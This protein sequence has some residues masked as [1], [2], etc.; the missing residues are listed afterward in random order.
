MTVA[1]RIMPRVL[2]ELEVYEVGLWGTDPKGK[3]WL[4]VPT[5]ALTGH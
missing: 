3:A 2:G 1:T 5:L 4:H